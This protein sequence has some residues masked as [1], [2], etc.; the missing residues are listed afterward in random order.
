MDGPASWLLPHRA[1]FSD[2]LP[3]GGAS[4][5]WFLRQSGQ[6][7]PGVG[8]GTL[9]W[10]VRTRS[11]PSVQVAQGG[12]W[13]DGLDGEGG[14]L[15]P[16][17][18]QAPHSAPEPSSTFYRAAFVTPS[19]WGSPTSQDPSLQEGPG[20]RPS[21]ARTSSSSGAPPP[22]G[23]R[24]APACP[25][26][27][28]LDPLLPGPLALMSPGSSDR[29]PVHPSNR[30]LTALQLPSGFLGAPDSSRSFWT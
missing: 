19:R 17:P 15:P 26:A 12:L 21:A 16:S 24:R 30:T 9:P 29:W 14:A 5:C 2:R 7:F 25:Q 18:A 1:E 20:A 28:F 13:R 27:P 10:G 8:M 22:P 23:G 11:A 6:L 3:S 4:A